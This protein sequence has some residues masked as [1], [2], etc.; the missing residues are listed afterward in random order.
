MIQTPT[1]RCTAC[2]IEKP[3]ADFPKCSRN[4]D[5]YNSR[6][7]DCINSANKHWRLSAVDAY[8]AMRKRSYQR[9]RETNLARSRVYAQEHRE[10]KAIYDK[11]YR[12]ENSKKRRAQIK[13]WELHSREHRTRQRLRRLF[14]HF[15]HGE[16]IKSG[17]SLVGCT[18]EFY[19]SY[20]EGLFKEGMTWDNHGEKGWHID[21]II[22]L[23]AFDLSKDEDI[24]RCF[25]Y[26]NTQPLWCNENLKKGKYAKEESHK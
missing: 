9:N 1:K 19:K 11:Q 3:L 14:N 7:K 20:I 16:C 15:M 2:L 13:E 4:K 26:S 18:F 25:H 17:E 6:C 23:A 10:E 8:R 12:K 24:K 22:P 5:G 21:H